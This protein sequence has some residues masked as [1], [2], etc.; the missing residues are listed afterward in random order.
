MAISLPP[1]RKKRRG[2]LEAF[3]YFPPR[4]AR[5]LP[6]E[7][8]ILWKRGIVESVKGVRQGE[9][10]IAERLHMATVGFVVNIGVICVIV[11]QLKSGLWVVFESAV[12]LERRLAAIALPAELALLRLRS[13]S[14]S[15]CIY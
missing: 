13:T 2:L 9:G 10:G 14:T 3:L 12:V 7:I 5:R 8:K 15:R 4:Q 1:I 6:A 11:G